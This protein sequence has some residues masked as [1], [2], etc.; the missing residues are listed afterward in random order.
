MK[1]FESIKVLP[2]NP[3]TDDEIKLII[4]TIQPSSFCFFDSTDIS[5]KNNKIDLTLYFRS[6]ACPTEFERIDTLNI[7]KLPLGK[8]E[9][10]SNLFTFRNKGTPTSIDDISIGFKVELFS[11]SELE[12]SSGI[13]VYPNPF[14]NVIQL[15]NPN[16]EKHDI[17]IF[18][19]VGKIVLKTAIE[20]KI[21][22]LDLDELQKGV[23]LI[24][25]SNENYTKSMRIVKN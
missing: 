22:S 6:F 23:Y 4:H 19:S 15:K 25:M 10:N 7:G 11:L 18:N 21:E 20:S 24:R 16:Q 5:M 1:I 13:S 8:Y 17:T 9:L 3:S 2:A 12:S 14:K